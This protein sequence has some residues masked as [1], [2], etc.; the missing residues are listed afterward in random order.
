MSPL[1][2]ALAPL[3]LARLVTAGVAGLGRAAPGSSRL[4][5]F[6]LLA[7]AFSV[8]KV[9]LYTLGT[10]L[11]LAREGPEQM[12]LFFVVLAAT[13]ILLSCGFSL[14]VD[15]VPAMRL[16]RLTMLTVLALALVMRGLLALDA[17]GIYFVVLIS[18]HVYDIVTDIVF[19][20]AAAAYFT[21]FELRRSTTSLHLALAAGG[22]VGG[23]LA[24]A[25]S[26]FVPPEDLLLALPPLALLVV[27][28]L[29]LAERRL[30]PIEG[31]EAQEEG[32]SLL[33]A[34]RL[35]PS[36][37]RR[38]PLILLLALNS[39][40][41][42]VVY[43]AAEYLYFTIYT[44][45][46]ADE[47]VMATFLAV[48]FAAIQVLEFVLLYVASRPLIERAAP[49]VR[50]LVFP[51]TSLAC[52]GGLA[53][54][55]S[56]PLAIAAQVNAEALSNAIFEP[57][58]N[59]NYS[60]VPYSLHGRVR[61]L[62]DGI[63][64]PGG[65]AVAGVMLMAMPEPSALAALSFVA[66]VCALVFFLVNFGI[67]VMFPPAL[68]RNL[69]A[70]VVHMAD[71]ADRPQPPIP[72]DQV[73]ALLRQTDPDARAIG[74]DLAERCDPGLLL[75]ELQALAPGA[76]RA[77]RRRIA[78]LLAR[79]S[80]R[81]LPDVLDELLASGDAA[82]QLIALQAV[83]AQA[84]AVDPGPI[85]QLAAAPDRSVAA[86]AR[87]AAGAAPDALADPAGPLAE[88]L[89]WCRDAEVAAD[90][91]D[92]CG[93]ARH[94]ATAD[95]LI[96]LIEV[97]P[98]EQQRAGLAV[99]ARIVGAANPRA[100]A[101]GS[102][103]A[104][105][106]DVGLRAAAAGVL[107][108]VP[109]APGVLEALG[110]ALGDRSRL[111]REQAVAAL[112]AQGDAAIP[113][114]ASQLRSG[115]PAA[116]EA[117]VR[118]LGRIGS[119]RAASALTA[120]LDAAYADAARNLDWLRQLPPGA[121]RR[122]WQVLELALEDRNQR[123]VD[124]VLQVAA[125]LGA[126]RS[127]T[128]LR[129]ALLT[130]DQRTRADA[131]EA[132]LASPQR[133]LLQPIA[134]LLVAMYAPAAA[135]TPAGTA[136]DGAELLALVCRAADPWLRRAAEHTA[137]RLAADRDVAGAAE[138]AAAVTT[139]P[140]MELMLFLKRVSLF[141]HLSLDTLMAVSRALERRHYLAGETIFEANAR[142]DHFSMV[143][144]GAV[145]LHD[146]G[147]GARQLRAPAHFGE[148]VLA[149]EAVRAPRVVAA[150]D[151]S[152][153]RLHRIVFRDLS[154]DHPEVLLEL[155]KLLARQLRLMQAQAPG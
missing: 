129:H 100:A 154:R 3:A 99:L 126:R 72:P 40:M 81:R 86:L 49:L 88:I 103:L 10:T 92:A 20:V 85:A 94:P 90:V 6:V 76:G 12:P 45:Q 142:W 52:L 73:C 120:L 7:A 55:P 141:R 77:E 128:D 29:A 91:I 68:V 14:V 21:S 79:A 151:T 35:L 130:H 41:L 39:L 31:E 93:Q 9:A 8:A 108:A 60:A 25:L 15:R 137:A 104:H 145:E 54:S 63:F 102:R 82:S 112:A 95:L 78:A 89:P 59:T 97:A 135:D 110:A 36:L 114:V 71:A 113:L 47:T 101:L 136:I 146:G 148:L 69:R 107:A 132:L 26:R 13:A 75:D 122:R 19:W 144:S 127:L 56:L 11:F 152:L 105:H 5:H 140:D 84:G 111:V 116:V 1:S 17:P 87:L 70:G 42:T 38:H 24:G 2:P 64:Y 80:S 27:A 33:A 150:E 125:A 98:L 74:L 57:V 67:G 149:D 44:R 16:F 138:P 155:C 66:V 32:G 4:G 28:Q 65:M 119:P 34:A 131:L 143:E 62:A 109:R 22:V 58:N 121:A 147:S 133:R 123:I 96:V 48:V 61:T 43:C 51:S 106:Q 139:E 118:C 50:N 153:L 134:A 53:I 117:A 115:D 30:P 37:I 83:L 124:L 23:L 46:F 18:A